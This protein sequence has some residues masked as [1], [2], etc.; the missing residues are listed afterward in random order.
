MVVDFHTHICPPR[1]KRERERYLRQDAGFAAL[2]SSPKA[3]LATAEEL[4]D[5]MDS[6]GIAISVVQGGGWSSHELCVEFND[7]I[8][9]S[10][11]RYPKRLVGFTTFQ[12]DSLDAAVAEIERCA[13]GGAAGIGELRPESLSVGL[14]DAGAMATL[15]AAIGDNGLPLLV[16]ASEPV[17]HRYQGKGTMTP[18]KLP[19]FIGSFSETT[20]VCAHWGGGLPFYAMMP[21]VGE[22]LA[23]VYFDSA[24]SP[25]LYRPEVY[26]LVAGLVGAERVLFGSD[27]PLLAQKR[28]LDDAAAAGLT[29]D[30]LALV[31]R[32]NACR[33]LGLPD[34]E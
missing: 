20:V 12:T 33:L 27:H 3:K 8:L 28:A 15:A 2:Y 24:A 5:S 32:G 22:A 14:G 4:I 18:E 19:L 16:H 30:E 11:A 1:V 34:A 29:D 7:Y 9:E 31:L 13:R 10:V 25:F 26:R 23:N 17:G 21:E 6:D